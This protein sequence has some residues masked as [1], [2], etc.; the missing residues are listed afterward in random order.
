M[1]MANTY[2]DDIAIRIDIRVTNPSNLKMNGWCF[3]VG[4]T[5][6]RRW[7]KRYFVLIQVSQYCFSLCNYKQRRIKPSGI[8]NLSGFTVDYVDRENAAPEGRS[9]PSFRLYNLSNSIYITVD[10]EYTRSAWIKALYRAT[11]QAKKPEML[12]V[13]FDS[14]FD[15]NGIKMFALLFSELLSD[16]LQITMSEIIARDLSFND[17]E[18]LLRLILRSTI[19]FRLNESTCSLGWLSVEQS[20]VIEE[21]CYRHLIRPI[22]RHICQL[23][24]MVTFAESGYFIDPGL[25]HYVYVSCASNLSYARYT[26]IIKHGYHRFYSITI[27]ERNEFEENRDRLKRIVIEHLTNFRYEIRFECSV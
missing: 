14:S 13:S 12:N 17:Y 15:P 6:W 24:E 27:N 26:S 1:K 8:L 10:S 19:M 7:K 11:G 21:Y 20:F 18:S 22:K 4:K 25:F 2:S 5:C 9:S 16:K 23:S 3:A